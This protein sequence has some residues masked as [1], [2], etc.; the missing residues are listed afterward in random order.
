MDRLRLLFR[1]AHACATHARPYTDYIW[2]CDLDAAKG[3]DI[4]NTYR[5]DKAAATFVEYIA[6]AQR[7]K[8]RNACEDVKFISLI[9]DGA[10]DSSRQEAE[11][12]YMRTGHRGTITTTFVGIRNLEKADARSITSAVDDMM[13]EIPD[14]KDKVV[15]Y[16]ADGASVMQGANSGAIQRVRELTN[17]PD[18]VGVHCSAHRLELAFKDAVKEI[19][20]F[21]KV[22]A[23]SKRWMHV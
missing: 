1:N 9:S 10:T 7:N 6:L 3:I 2:Q 14:W 22:D 4:G 12:L 23:C 20:L 5:N 18:L 11:I 17:T 15:G 13:G 19:P 16:S 8:V 21:K